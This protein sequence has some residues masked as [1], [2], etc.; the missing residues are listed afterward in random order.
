MTHI[1]PNH[2]FG[3]YLVSWMGDNTVRNFSF[4]NG[5]SFEKF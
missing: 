1:K 3:R 4:I 5:S 2:K